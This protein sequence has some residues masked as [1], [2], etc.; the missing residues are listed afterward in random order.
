MNTDLRKKI[1]N[2]LNDEELN[3][4]K[5]AYILHKLT[6]EYELQH[7]GIRESV[8]LQQLFDD[9]MKSIRNLKVNK[10][11]I[12]TGFRGLDR[13]I[14]G[15]F[16]GEFI[17]IG[18]RPAMGKTQLLVNLALNISKSYPVLYYNFDLPPFLIGSRFMSALSN[19][20]INRILEDSLSEQEEDKLIDACQVLGKHKIFINDSGSNSLAAIKSDIISHVEK[21]D[22]KVVMIDYLQQMSTSRY[23]YNRDQEISAICREL[24]K[25]ARDH[26][27]V[28][29]VSS[30]LGR[31]VDQR[32]GTKR[33][34]LSD[35]RESGSIEQDA[36]K[37]FMIY[38]MEYYGFYEDEDGNSTIGMVDLILAKNRSGVVGTFK[39]ISDEAFTSFT[40]YDERTD[41]FNITRDR[42]GDLDSPF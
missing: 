12:F 4:F 37:V 18:G 6:Q 38:R 35:L 41:N 36:D 7:T 24:K 10:S 9:T 1:K 31:A 32:G 5:L 29:I 40:D 22:V 20:G 30:Q 34:Q 15:F 8:P 27:L 21:H 26:H 13:H 2:I 42:L 33:P 17:V 14:R 28:I 16:P 3:D 11:F 23:K 25:L 19:I 39:L